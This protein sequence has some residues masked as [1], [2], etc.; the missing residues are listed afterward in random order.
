ML[1]TLGFQHSNNSIYIYFKR[2]F[3]IIAPVFIDDIILVSKDNSVMIF[4]VQEL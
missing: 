3:K 2:D 1:D 4:I